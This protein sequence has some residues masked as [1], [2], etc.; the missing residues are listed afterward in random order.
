MFKKVL[1]F[2]AI[3]LIAIQAKNL[4]C[5]P[6]RQLVCKMG[7]HPAVCCNPITERCYLGTCWPLRVPFPG[8]EHDWEKVID[9]LETI[10]PTVHEAVE[11]VRL[12]AQQKYS[13]AIAKIA[14]LTK[15]GQTLVEKCFN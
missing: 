4:S 14:D 3:C 5:P 8:N 7:L 10:E 9:C 1:F 11:M 12:I 2:L 15:E 13:E 6:D